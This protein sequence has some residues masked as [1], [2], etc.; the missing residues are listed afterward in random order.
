MKDAATG[1]DMARLGDSTDHGGR[2]VEASPDLTHRN[3]RVALDGHLVEC[4]ACGGRFP[5]EATGRRTHRGVRVAFIGDQTACGA[6]LIRR[7]KRRMKNHFRNY[8]DIYSAPERPMMID[9][10]ALPRWTPPLTPEHY[11][12][13]ARS[14]PV[15]D[16]SKPV[17]IPV[18]LHGTEAIGELFHY[19]VRVMTDIDTYG[20]ALD[21]DSIVGTEV[22]VSI[23]VPGKGTFVSGMPGN[24]GDGNIGFHVRKISGYVSVARFVRRDDRSMVYEFEIEPA[25]KKATLG[26]NWRIFQNCTVIEAISELLRGYAAKIDWRIAGPLH[27]SHYPRRDLQ[28]QYYESDYICFKRWCERAG[29]FFWFDHD[30]AHTIV[31]A[32]TMGAFHR[33]GEAYRT[34]RYAPDESRT[35]EETI[36]RLEFAS[37]QTA[38]NATGVDHDYT[39]P[40][41]RRANIPL[42]VSS[43]DPRDTARADQEFYEYVNTSQPLQGAMGLNAEPLDA[44]EQARQAAMVR[45]QSLRCQGLRATG[46]GHLRALIPGKTFHLAEHPLDKANQEYIVVSTTLT[47]EANAQASGTDQA[48]RCDTAFE[49]CPILAGYF[50]LPIVTPWPVAGTEIAIV[51][52]PDDQQLWTDALGRVKCQLVPDRAGRYDENSFIWLR[53]TQPGRTGRWG[54]RSCHA[55]IAKFWLAISTAIPTC[56]ISREA[57]STQIIRPRGH[58]PTT[59]GFRAC[60]PEWRKALRQTILRWTIRTTGSR[61]SLPAIM[62]SR[63]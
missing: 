29:L 61:R 33:H 42:R 27:G 22:T 2:I 12:R 37:R 56:R 8:S 59:N 6:T 24:T 48:F 54:R 26:Q 20:E 14:L 11:Y 45:M 35:D 4:P 9:G 5:I 18:H 57:L 21:L 36:A 23:D 17:L 58:C 62:Q 46:H 55:S 28:R 10:A 16:M 15:E 19:T 50:R 13:K 51:S 52:G 32:D 31:I 47:M 25:L 49:L 43:E 30:N 7:R 1:R 41:M 53:V 39:E 40:R 34:I 63:A 38:G 60:A 44:R 3:V